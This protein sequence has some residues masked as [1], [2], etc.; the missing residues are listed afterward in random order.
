MSKFAVAGGLGEGVVDADGGG[1]AVGA[2]AVQV[3]VHD[4]QAGGVVDD[5]P[6]VQGAVAE[7]LPLVAVEGVVMLGDVVVGGEQ[8]A[9][10]AAGGVADGEAGGGAHDVDDGLDERAGG[11]VLARAGLGILGVLFEQAFVDFALDVQVHADPGFAVDQLDQ[12]LELGGVL[13][14]VLGFAED[15]GDEARAQA[16]LVEDFAVV[17]FEVGAGEAAQAGPV[18]F[19]G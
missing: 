11:E 9:A 2:D 1:A 10:G 3:E 7:V 4:A 8:E 15:G 19:G 6:A 18:V 16:E 12:A 14:A 17:V 5:F 13:D